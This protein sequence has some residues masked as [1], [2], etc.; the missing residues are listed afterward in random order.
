MTTEEKLNCF[1]REI[2]SISEENV[3]K[4]A[5]LL[6]SNTEEWFYHEPASTSGK[7]HPDFAQGDGGLLRH[8]QALVY[9]LNEF[10]RTMMYGIN[11]HEWNLLKVAAIAHDIRKHVNGVY[12]KDHAA[13][14]VKFVLEVHE[15]YGLINESDVQVIV[16]TVAS[17][18][19]IWD[20][21]K[22]G[23]PMPT[24]KLEIMLAQADICASR[25]ECSLNIFEKD[26]FTEPAIVTEQKIET[27]VSADSIF[28]WGKHRGKT[29]GEV[30]NIDKSWMEWVV[31]C[32]NFKHEKGKEDIIKFLNNLK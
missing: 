32:E 10:Q 7:Y 6:L 13:Q 20:H 14:A 15:K 3:R 27:E 28:N 24:T 30:Y 9:W 26:L 5:M 4:F 19:G 23:S 22:I 12:V 25:K 31:S 21:E 11:E 1:N 29:F 2:N 16:S 18:M 17:H 8:T